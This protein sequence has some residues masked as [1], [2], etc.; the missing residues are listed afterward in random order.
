VLIAD[1]RNVR[2][3]THAKV[4]NDRVD[5][6]MIAKLG[7][8]PQ[9]CAGQRQALVAVVAYFDAEQRATIATNGVSRDK[10]ANGIAAYCR[11]GALSCDH[12]KGVS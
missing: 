5:A 8:R 9:V 7:F 6:R 10:R 2:A 11:G 1:T 12:T 3:M 4:K